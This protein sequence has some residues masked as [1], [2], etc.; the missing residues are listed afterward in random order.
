MPTPATGL[1]Y[2]AHD[3]RRRVAPRLP[4]RFDPFIPDSHIMSDSSPA[5]RIRIDI[6]SDYVCPFCYLLTP[7]L[8]QLKQ[9]FGPA[10]QVAWRGFELRPDPRPTLDPAGEYLRTTWERSVYPMARERGMTLK[11][12]PVQP[13]SRKAMEAAAYAQSEGKSDEMHEALFR[14]FFEEGRDIG[15]TEVL[16]DIGDAAGLQRDALRKALDENTFAAQVSE[17][18]QLARDFGISGVPIMVIREQRAPWQDAVA[19]EGA[20]PY[21]S[22]RAAV[23]QVIGEAAKKG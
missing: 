5:P 14:A 23:G 17:D 9:E 15:Q 10:L 22:M 1:V 7:A 18:Q 8:H 13:R 6:W 3:L 19:L 16:L 20:V 4:F 21:E 2:R 11:L 12:P